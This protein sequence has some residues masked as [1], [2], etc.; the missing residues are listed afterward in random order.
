MRNEALVPVILGHNAFFGVDHLSAERGS[1]RAAHFADSTKILDVIHLARTHGVGG[2]MMSTHER[3]YDIADAIRADKTLREGLRIYPLLPY[4]QKYVTRAN[5]VG[6]VNVVLEM[7]SG[8]SL[9]GK[10][11]LL[12]AGSKA[13]LGKDLNA[14]L[15]ALMRIELKAFKNLDVGAVF[16]HD[17]FTDLALA[18]ELPEIFEFY[19]K[20]VPKICGGV[21]AFASKNLPTFLHKFA[22]WGLE[23]PLVMAHFNK[24]G[25]QMNPGRAECEQ[26]ASEHEASILAMGPLA[27][28]Y[29]KPKD[30][31][32]YLATVKN[33]EGVVVGMSRPRHIEETMVAIREHLFSQAP[34]PRVVQ[35]EST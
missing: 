11:N 28:G 10:L 33:I 35:A 19:C 9:S 1:E 12:W 2:M 7:L 32:S 21:G 4:A 15:S 17:L 16:L 27:A 20:E 8:T 24:T 23:S 29:L 6:M 5:E 18:F 30:A 34:A 31:F 26:A 3:A 13:T 14:A 25:F 22:E